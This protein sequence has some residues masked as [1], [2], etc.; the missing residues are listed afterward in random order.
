MTAP[1]TPAPLKPAPTHPCARCGDPVALDVGLCERCNPLGLRDSA[2]SQV[3]G[4]VV[5]AVGLAIATLAI[6][7]R[8]AVNGIGPFIAEVGVTQAAANGTAVTIDIRVRNDGRT[9]GS[10]TCQVSDPLDPGLVNRLVVYSPRI[11]GGATAS[12]TQEVPFGTAGRI[13]TVTCEGP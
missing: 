11:A 8:L 12:W 9:T 4:T 3:H 2:S 10:A 6:L 7:A 5:V 13:L 1:A